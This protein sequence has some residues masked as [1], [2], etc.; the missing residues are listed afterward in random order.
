MWVEL[1]LLASA[2]LV[3]WPFLAVLFLAGVFFEHTRCHG[4]AVFMGI[5]AAVVSYFYLDVPFTTILEWAVG[6]LAIGV[7]WSF[8]RYNSHVSES[9]KA[10]NES[11]TVGVY[12]REKVEALAPGKNLDLITTWIIIWPFS[13]V[14]NIL[15]DI[16]TFIQTLVTKVFRSVYAKIYSAHLAALK[17]PVE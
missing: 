9:V 4:W 1:G 8:W 3:T 14:E 15:G 2:Y 5:L 12:L 11:N 10:L 7:V 17:N 16:L 6:Y 13:A